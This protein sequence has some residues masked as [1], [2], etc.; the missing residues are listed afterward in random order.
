L[1]STKLIKGCEPK[2]CD[3]G[4]KWGLIPLDWSMSLSEN[5]EKDRKAAEQYT[6]IFDVSQALE[7]VG[8]DRE[9]LAEVVGLTQAA[10]PTLLENIRGGVARGDLR[11]VESAARVAKAAA[12][13]VSASRA[14]ESALQLVRTA[15]KGDL[16]AAQMASV[17]WE[18]E[19]E[20][21][22]IFLATLG[23]SECSS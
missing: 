3:L 20:L 10:W 7:S 1:Y 9:F 17:E 8:G 11:A 23:E 16:D 19:V 6:E 18:R 5:W 2:G 21:L 4:F 12:Q 13:N 22:R 14:Y 15:R